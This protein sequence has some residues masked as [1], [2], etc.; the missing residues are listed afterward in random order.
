MSKADQDIKTIR[1]H[2]IELRRRLFWVALVFGIGAAIGFAANQSIIRWLVRPLG[3]SLYFTTPSGGLDFIFSISCIAGLLVALPI[4]IFQVVEFIRPAHSGLQNLKPLRI[5]LLSTGCAA[6]GVGYAYFI[7]IPAALHFLINFAGDEVKPL[8]NA[9]SYMN[10]IITYLAGA[11]LVFQIPLL[12][13]IRNK[14]SPLK[15]GGLSKLQRPVILGAVIGA[16]IITP[17]PDPVNQMMLALPLIILFQ[18]TAFYFWQKRL[19]AARKVKR[20][21]SG[22]ELATTSEVI[23]SLD[24]LPTL[25][26][27]PHAGGAGAYSFAPPSSDSIQRVRPAMPRTPKDQPERDEDRG[28]F[29]LEGAVHSQE[30]VSASVFYDIRPPLHRAG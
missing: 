1:E 22:S 5:V 20:R 11:A 15:P 29:A 6:L 17:T 18:C 16:G 13:A 24:V 28:D 4:I 12:V 14:I 27:V 30:S 21:T 26:T 8:L 23:P 9:T 10:F 2:L 3:Q 19:S 25:Q 7:G